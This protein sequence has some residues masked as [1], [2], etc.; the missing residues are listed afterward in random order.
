MCASNEFEKDFFKLMVNC[1]YGKTM[2]NL[3]KRV[4]VKL[5]NN[6]ED[7]VKGVSRPTFVSQKILS[8]NLVAIHRVRPVLTLNKPICVGFCV[9]EL[10]KLFIYDFHYNYFKVIYDIELLFTDTDSLVYKVEDA[11]DV[12]ER[13]YS[14]KY[15][16]DF[17][18][19]SRD[20]R[21]YDG[22]KKKVIGKMKNEIGGKVIFEFIGLKSKMHSLITV[23]D[24]E[25]TK[26]K[27]LSKK[28]GLKYSEFFY[29]LFDKKIVRHNM[30][31]IQAKKHRL[32]TYDVCKV[33]LL[34]F[35]DK[36]Y[37]LD[38]GVIVLLIFIKI[39]YIV[40]DYL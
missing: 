14:D 32:G 9:L 17:S 30:K 38:I 5:V 12:Y 23:D 33:S 37:L 16:F 4:N 11:D 36:R 27:G 18:N 22:S 7:Y 24:E 40:R 6:G 28:L 29:V 26:A 10:S 20:S 2:E 15:L 31:R 3:R 19:Y 35:D 34:C 1:V 8:G 13:V 39:L 25:K 21:F